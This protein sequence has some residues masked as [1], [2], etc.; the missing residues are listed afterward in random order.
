MT[1]TLDMTDIESHE[2]VGTYIVSPG[3]DNKNLASAADEKASVEHVAVLK[4]TAD[5]S[6]ILIPQPCDD[7][8]DTLNWSNRKKWRVLAV[9]A[10]CAAMPD[11]QAGFGIPLV[12]P[13][14]VYWDISIQDSG[15]SMSG[16][17]FMIGVGSLLSVPLVQ[18]YGRLPVLWWSMFLSFWMSLAATLV[19]DHISFIVVRCLQTTFS[20]APQVIGLSFIYDMFFFHQHARA[21]GIWA[22]AFVESPFVGPFI[23]G[24]IAQYYSWRH[25]FGACTAF[26]GVAALLVLLFGEET[27]YD[28]HDNAQVPPTPRSAKVRRFYMLTGVRGAKVRGRLSLVTSTRRIL[29]VASK[30]YFLP[31]L[32]SY[33]LSFM[34]S[35]GINTSL[36]LILFMP[37]DDGGYSFSQLNVAL[38][39]IAPIAAT[40]LGELFGH[41]FND[42]VAD[43]Y[44]RKH[45]GKFDPEVRLWAAGIG[46]PFMI[47]GL[48]FLGFC[49]ERHLSWVAIAFAW[50]I[51]VFGSLMTTVAITAYALDIFK[52]EAAEAAALINFFR[53]IGGFI[54]NYFQVQWAAAAGSDASFG[55]QAAIC[56]LAWILIGLVQ[57][58]GRNWRKN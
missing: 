50:G 8:E 40:A 30:P 14:S 44:I 37:I 52:E 3:T 49:L 1:N 16:N 5:G 36:N 42:W 11:S 48:T 18:R 43:K 9:V 24:I 17:V 45:D 55:T 7:P 53:T 39:Y 27:L 6:T 51:Y 23:S 28:R 2:A 22:W 26:T 13:Q 10:Y 58:Q 47:G 25:S 29:V 4:K 12:V 21:I 31:L 38:L 15:R 35:V 57:W 32:I 20:A 19:P 41:Y 54:V 33:G 56:A 46:Q 34:W